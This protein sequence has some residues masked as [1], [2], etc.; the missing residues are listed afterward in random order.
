MLC[1]CGHE[2]ELRQMTDETWV[3]VCDHC[4]A[5]Y[6]SDAVERR[7]WHETHAHLA[8]LRAHYAAKGDAKAVEALQSWHR[9]LR[10]AEAKTVAA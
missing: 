2:P 8:N 5:R 9:D 6:P 7:L 1:N 10:L 4:T 3:Y